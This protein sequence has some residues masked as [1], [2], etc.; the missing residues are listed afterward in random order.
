V[1]GSPNVRARLVL[2][3]QNDLLLE[4]LALCVAR[5]EGYEVAGTAGTGQAGLALV[6][7]TAPD[8]V[9]LNL[10]LPDMS[11]LTAL[12]RM[13]AL[14]RVPLVIMMT[15]DC[16]QAARAAIRDLGA[17]DCIVKSDIAKVIRPTVERLLRERDG[18]GSQN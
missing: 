11:G 2:V 6:E 5:I 13:K 10:T 17:D 14:P 16:S 8:V 7:R 15:F 1:C 4:M 18:A 9:L 12:L 3:D